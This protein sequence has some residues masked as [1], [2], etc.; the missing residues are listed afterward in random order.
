MDEQDYSVSSGNV[1]AD[2]RLPDAE[3]LLAKSDV[4]A[5][6]RITLRDRNLTPAEAAKVMGL[7]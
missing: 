4:A 3:Y 7:P 6:I 2:L 1:F 5:R